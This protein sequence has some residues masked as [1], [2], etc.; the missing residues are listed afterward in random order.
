MTLVI[1]PTNPN[2]LYTYPPSTV[3]SIL[4]S[5][6]GGQSGTPLRHTPKP[7]DLDVQHQPRQRTVHVHWLVLLSAVYQHGRRPDLVSDRLLCL[8]VLIPVIQPRQLANRLWYRL[9]LGI[10]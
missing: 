4:R 8:V 6:D 3:Q 10:G 2:V 9:E 7:A 5:T 1:D